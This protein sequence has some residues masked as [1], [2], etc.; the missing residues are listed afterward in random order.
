MTCFYDEMFFPIFKEKYIDLTLKNA[1][2]MTMNI[3]HWLLAI[4]SDWKKDEDE[5]LI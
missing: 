4:L 3:F 2:I 1:F 5:R